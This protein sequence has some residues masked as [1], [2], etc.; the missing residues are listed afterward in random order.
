MANQKVSVVFDRKTVAEK[1]GQGIVKMQV[2]LNRHE[3]KYIVIG[4]CSSY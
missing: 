1:R 2:Y 4:K 3:R